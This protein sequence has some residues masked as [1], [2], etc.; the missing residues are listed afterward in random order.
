MLEWAKRR[1]AAA[2]PGLD[3]AT[4][5]RLTD[6]AEKSQRRMKEAQAS[7]GAKS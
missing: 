7:E 1:R 2:Q 6:E 4:K 3:E 5:T